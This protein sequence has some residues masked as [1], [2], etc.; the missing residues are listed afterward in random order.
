MSTSGASADVDAARGLAATR[1]SEIMRLGLLTGRRIERPSSSG[2][3]SGLE[4]RPVIVVTVRFE[5]IVRD[6][7]TRKYSLRDPKIVLIRSDKSASEADEASAL[8][9]LYLDQRLS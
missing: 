1:K 2:V 6:A 5:G 3:R 7:V 9:R 4:F 8:E